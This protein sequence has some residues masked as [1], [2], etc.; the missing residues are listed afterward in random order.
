[1]RIKTEK[2]I[3]WSNVSRFLTDNRTTITQ[4]Y[5]SGTHKDSV[6]ELKMVVEKWKRKHSQN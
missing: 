2:L 3:R 5:N 6:A 1:M 4:A